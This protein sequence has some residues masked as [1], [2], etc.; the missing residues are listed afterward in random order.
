M[1]GTRVLLRGKDY[2]YPLEMLQ[3]LFGV[4]PL[5]SARILFDYSIATIKID[6]RAG[7][8]RRL[9]RRL[10]RPQPRAHALRP[11][12]R[13]LFRAGVGPADQ[14]DFIEAGAARRQAESQEHHPAH[15]RHQ[16]RSD[17]LFHEIF[18]SAQGHQRAVRGHGAEV[19]AGG[20]V[21]RSNA[22][23]I[24]VERDGDRVRAAS[25]TADGAEQTIDCDVRALDA[26][27]A[28]AREHGVAGA[29][30]AGDRACREAAL[31]QPEADLHRAQARRS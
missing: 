6:V 1:R 20:N 27:A 15:A 31:P 5:L 4:S 17:D 14:P 8:E 19:R 10:G 11:V 25:S 23:A 16:G 28:G 7:Q 13:H 18:L 2:V 30:G 22:P 9:V 12:L 3:V 24:R 26:A 21:L 29:A